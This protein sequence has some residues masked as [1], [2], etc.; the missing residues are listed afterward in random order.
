MRI[1][2]LFLP[3]IL[4]VAIISFLITPSPVVS[5]EGDAAKVRSRSLS[6]MPSDPPASL[7][8]IRLESAPA[9]PIQFAS[10]TITQV[11][12]AAGGANVLFDA[13]NEPSIAVDP[14]FPNKMAIGW[15]QFNSTSSNFRM[16]GWA[17]T[18]D[19]G[20]TWTFPGVLEPGV[21]R[22]DPVL[23]FDSLGNF[24]YS[25]LHVANSVFS[26]DFFKSWDGGMTWGEKIPAYGGDKQWFTVDRT[27]GQGDGNIYHAWSQ[28]A[29]LCCDDSTFN[30]SVD[31]GTRF[32][33]PQAMPALP[34]WG[35]LTVDPDG[36][37]YIAG[38]DIDDHSLF[39]VVKS[40]NAQNASIAPV[41]DSYTVVDMGGS[42]SAL[43]GG[44]TPN[45][46]GLLGPVWIDADHS[47]GPYDGY[48][49]MLASVTP[50]GDDPLDI[51]FV[52]SVDGGANWSTPVR[53]ND[54]GA[55][56]AWQWFGT[57][58]VAPNGRIDAIWNDTRNTGLY[59]QSQLFYAYSTDAGATWSTNEAAS[60]V[61]DSQIGWPNQN[62]IGDYYDMVSDDVGANLAW[63]ATFNGEQDVYYTRIGDY[64]CNTNGIGDA[65]DI[66]AG[67][68]LDIDM[69]GI[70]DE[71][72]DFVTAASPADMPSYAL[73][74][75]VP[76][77]FNPS[78]TIRFDVPPGGGHVRIQIFDVGGR[79]MTTLIDRDETA[80]LKTVA[81]NGKGRDGHTVP[82]GLYFYRLEAPRFSQTRKMLFIK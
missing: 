74:Q 23:G 15:R 14:T 60:P 81:W 39:Y 59:R 38:T 36:A 18:V 63:A 1:R 61:F 69:N 4:P 9:A 32:S 11:N 71:C 41:F 64:D 66:G 40:T 45:P 37:L 55:T 78:T 12:V 80:G 7:K 24:Y 22:S 35:T 16:A 13:A 58:S 10:F 75:N 51:H 76:N 34:V 54:D 20:R 19:G 29:V 68:S 44:A 28:A 8:E 21:F 52:R 56:N 57:M 3:A 70:P 47:G 67:T 46:D 53:V 27:G 25:S 43:T 30:R 17:Y 77:P 82:S 49:Y 72:E 62:K 65:I 73:Y 79:L 33:Y 26:I 6:E 50:P 2:R 31:G 42:L 48:I 5:A